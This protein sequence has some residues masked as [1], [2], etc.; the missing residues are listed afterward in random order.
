MP[1]TPIT[2]RGFGLGVAAA[3]LAFGSA[4]AEPMQDRVHFIIPGGAGGGWDGAARG[5]GEAL[6]GAKIVGNASFEDLSGG[7]GG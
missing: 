5:V 1:F 7:G 6:V 4:V 2:R 3:A